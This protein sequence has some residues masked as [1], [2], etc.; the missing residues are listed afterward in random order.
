MRWSDWSERVFHPKAGYA[1]DSWADGYGIWYA[2]D[3]DY[4]NK[5]IHIDYRGTTTR[6]P[7]VDW[8][9]EG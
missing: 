6:Y 4:G 7:Q 5:M 3:Q 8:E 1:V 9:C 2:Q